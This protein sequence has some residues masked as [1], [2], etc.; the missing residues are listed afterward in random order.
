MHRVVITAILLAAKFFDDAYYNN[1]YY[2]KV[3]GVLVSEMN[4]LEVDFL[5][6]INFSLHVT[7]ELFH[8][9]R[10]ELM[11]H[12]GGAA[13]PAAPV[14]QVDVIPMV[15]GGNQQ[16]S[17]VVH[18]GNGSHEALHDHIVESQPA[19]MLV[20]QPPLN[21][22]TDQAKRQPTYITPSPPVT[23]ARTA[24]LPLNGAEIIPSVA[25]GMMASQPI[26]ATSAAYIHNQKTL[27][28][29]A[30][31]IVQ[32]RR[33]SPEANFMPSTMVAMAPD[34]AAALV[35][36]PMDAS[37]K[38]MF[39]DKVGYPLHHPALV[40]H[41]HPVEMDSSGGTMLQHHVPHRYQ[42]RPDAGGYLHAAAVAPCDPSPS[43]YY[44]GGHVI[45]GGS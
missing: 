1:A 25:T 20:A 7:P 27:H 13:A 11:S 5:F 22:T 42:G 38:F 24:A 41:N 17:S 12:A 33:C 9:Y 8:K 44:V 29:P 14:G 2:A 39:V 31:P 18:L 45:T 3:G 34:A 19:P 16:M 23:S 6:R 32:H 43:Q 30:F 35:P 28:M 26:G 4:G 36:P 37:Q 15:T 10:E 21:Y 40:H